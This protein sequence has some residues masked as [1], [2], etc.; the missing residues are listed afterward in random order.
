[1][2]YAT[3]IGDF[4]FNRTAVMGDDNED[5][6]DI[7]FYGAYMDPDILAAHGVKPRHQRLAKLPGY[8]LRLGEKAT[9]LVS[10]TDSAVGCVYSLYPHEIRQLYAA[11]PD[12]YPITDAT[13]L[14]TNGLRSSVMIMILSEP[15]AEHIRN[16]DYIRNMQQILRKLGFGEEDINRVDH[17]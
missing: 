7:L 17:A 10:P 1:M 9:L 6:V 16:V 14:L 4:Q 13:A 2:G 15:P 3:K 11:H 8:R 5:P 12:Y